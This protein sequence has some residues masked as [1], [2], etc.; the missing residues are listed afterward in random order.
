MT[1]DHDP[2]HLL[3]AN[4]GLPEAQPP[5]P[6]RDKL[7]ITAVRPVVTAPEGLPLV[8][9]KVETSEPGLY[10]L[11]CATFTQ[12]Y[13]AVAAAVA[14]HVGPL[15]VG[16]HPADIEDITRTV[17]FSSYWRNGP[18]LNNALSGLDQALWDIAGK[19]AGMPVHELLGGR[20]RGGIEVY[21]HA[22]GADT[23]EVLDEAE[24]LIAQGY[25]N[26][27]LQ[28]S[29]P[30]LGS[31]GAPGTGGHYPGSPNPDGWDPERYLRNT[32]SLFEAARQRLGR[33][34]NLMHDV[35]SR[36]T[37]KQA[38]V[39]ARALEPYGLS[40]LEDVIPSEHYD[41]LPE[42]RAA[43]PVPLAVGEQL[44][45]VVDAA[46]LIRDGG[47]DLIRLHTSAV[48][49][50]TPTRK[51]AALAELCGVRT[52]FHSPADVSPIGV[53]ANLAVDVSSPAF[54]FQ[55]SHEYNEAAHEVFP[56]C[57][58]VTA[59]YMYP[60]NE[61]GWGVDL[62]ERE[63]AKYPP[64]KFLFDRWAAVVRRPDGA[65]EAP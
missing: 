54:G 61:P 19:R 55:E 11:G 31:Y 21:T 34:I 36:L 16:R 38:I 32:P 43:S 59:G 63:A 65:L 15:A 26:I 37:P 5:W 8:V 49:G 48:G 50:L 40:F 23:A 51:L 25:R 27:R 33:E 62:D 35:H 53:A 28:R 57:P 46:R 7:R 47:V 4:G 13:A 60:S 9:V 20:V 6:A 10:G 29:E 52:A 22:S 2:N 41:R 24:R 64:T 58:D 56:G 1:G 45:S 17:H 18:V 39:L 42:V 44:G 30:G 14:E 3:D 12:R